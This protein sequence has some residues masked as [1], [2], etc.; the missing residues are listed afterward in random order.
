MPSLEGVVRALGLQPH[1][2]GGYFREVFRAAG[3]GGSR[4]AMTS[5]YYMPPLARP[6]RWRMIDADE[7]WSFHAGAPLS[8]SVS[9]DGRTVEIHRLGTDYAAGERPQAI[10][11]KG[12]WARAESHGGW[13]L[14]GGT[15][16]PG[17]VYEGFRMAP[18]DWQPGDPLP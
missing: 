15:C 4:G 18:P 12:A 10:V 17:F 16:A 1:P 8:L 7:V 6:S 11:P 2:E 13:S 9:R 5:I 14:V 3:P